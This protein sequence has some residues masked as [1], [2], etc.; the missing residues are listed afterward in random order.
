MAGYG[1]IGLTSVTCANYKK[2]DLINGK[3]DPVIS[4]GIVV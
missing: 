3:G 4:I 1:V 2:N